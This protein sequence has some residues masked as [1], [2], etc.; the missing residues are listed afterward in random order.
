MATTT[1]L[2]IYD[3]TLRDGNQ[4]LGISLSCSDKLRIATRLHES[5]IHYIE[6]GWPTPGNAIDAEFFRRAR[7]EAFHDR[8]VAFGATRRKGMSWA[9]DELQQALVATGAPAVTVFGKSWDLHVRKVIDTSLT[10]NL[11]MIAESVGQLKRRFDTVLFDAEHF[12]DGYRAN[13]EYALKTLSAARDA[14]ADC[15]VLCDTNGG[16]LPGEFLD[17]FRAVRVAYDGPLGVHMHNDAGC[18]VANSLLGVQEGAVQVQ[19]TMNG[20]G[21]RCGNANLCT[22]VPGLQLKRGVRVVSDEQLRRLTETSVFISEVVNVGHDIRQPYVGES[23]FSHKAGTH[24]DGVRKV[25]ESFEHVPP[26]LVG[27]TRRFVVSDQAGTATILE[28][29]KDIAPDIGKQ[30]P[31]VKAVLRRILEMEARGYQFE[32]ADGT[33]ELVAREVLGQFVQPFLVKGFR[34]IEEHRESGE[35]ISEATIKVEHDGQVEH[36]AANGDGPVNALDNALRKALV[37]FFPSLASVR[38]EDFKVRVLD[39]K[40]GTEAKVRV[41]IESS[42]GSERWGTVGMSPNI[43]EASWLA[44]VDSLEYKLM[45]EHMARLEKAKRRGTRAA[46]KK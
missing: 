5:G 38:L 24:A 41:L 46:P 14:G 32:A 16:L 23:A 10:E 42:D 6:G 13:P 22:I 44:L 20:L 36:T 35:L 39:A 7:R 2:S 30:D 34:V 40:A 45:K 43:I 12:F 9:Q 17:M 26:E 31:R 29:L 19:G 18:A 4:A 8:L 15:V 28:R 33:F 11:D 37:R 27:N 1:P 25:R 3:T 21:E